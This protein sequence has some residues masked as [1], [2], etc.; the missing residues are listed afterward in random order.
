MNKFVIINSLL[1][2]VYSIL[3]I[4]FPYLLAWLGRTACKFEQY[5]ESIT[6]HDRMGSIWP[7]LQIICIFMQDLCSDVGF[8]YTR[9]FFSFLPHD[10]LFN[11]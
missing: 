9:F 1:N 6:N 4:T 11:C 5:E 2:S 10:T 8:I 3:Y 7:L